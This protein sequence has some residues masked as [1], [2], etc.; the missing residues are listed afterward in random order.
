MP[1]AEAVV[2][3]LFVLDHRLEILVVL[4]DLVVEEPVDL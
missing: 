4:V 2:V 3:D 1:L